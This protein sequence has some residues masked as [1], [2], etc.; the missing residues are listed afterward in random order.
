MPIAGL[1]PLLVRH[2]QPVCLAVPCSVLSSFCG[3]GGYSCGWDLGLWLWDLLE[4]G[5][6]DKSPGGFSGEWLG[7][8]AAVVSTCEGGEGMAGWEL[9]GS[10]FRLPI[11]GLAVG[12][13]AIYIYICVCVQQVRH[14]SKSNAWLKFVASEA[15]A[16]SST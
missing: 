14:N 6:D 4:S 16:R 2:W 12:F 7:D 8:F 11:A 3:D 9:A 13:G 10:Y 5:S 1:W 15:L